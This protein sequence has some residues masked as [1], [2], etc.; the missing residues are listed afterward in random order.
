[1][2]VD[3]VD[4]PF[5]PAPPAPVPVVPAPLIAG[6]QLAAIHAGLAA[7]LQAA[8][9]AVQFQ[10]EVLPPRISKADWDRLTRKTP[11][12]GLGWVS[13]Q[14]ESSGARVW[15][16]VSKWMVV[17]VA[18]GSDPAAQMLGQTVGAVA[19]AGLYGMTSVA[20]AALHGLSIADIGTAVVGPGTPIYAEDWT[21]ADVE[22]AAL[23]VTVPFSLT[24][25]AGLAALN[26]FLTAGVAY[27]N[28][29]PLGADQSQDVFLVNE[30]I[31]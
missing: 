26:D 22:H 23:D 19:I 4:A 29:A 8:F 25:D 31:G 30:G 17:L 7:R 2:A 1:M 20:A 5:S 27:E 9:P 13:M 10:F 6:G 11:T 28:L 16:G 18:Q 14:P 15:R 24:D 12:V 21:K 3:V